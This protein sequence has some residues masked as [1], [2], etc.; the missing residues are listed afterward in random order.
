MRI[1]IQVKRDAAAQVVLNTL[2]KMSDLQITFGV[3][4]IAIVHG[5]PQLLSCATAC[6]LHRPP[7]HGGHPALALRAAQGAR[8]AGDRRGPR[9]RDRRDRPHHRAHPRL[10]GPGRGAPPCA[11][12]RW[13][14]RRLPR[15]HRSPAGRGRGR[16]G[17]AVPPQRAPGQGDPRH[18]AAAADRPRAREDRGRVPR[19]VRD[20]LVPRVDPRRPGAADGGDPRRA[21]GD[22]QRVRRRAPHPDGRGRGGDRGDRPGRRRADD[23]DA[24]QQRLHQAP[25]ER[26]VPRARAAAASASRAASAATRPTSSPSCSR[27]TRTRTCCCSPTP[28]AHVPHAGVRAA[29]GR[30][31]AP[32]RRWSTSSTCA[33]ASACSAWCRTATR[34]STTAST[35]S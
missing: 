5:R 30:R 2:Y 7:P 10:E 32:A 14:L 35:T 34:T 17:Q 11:P 25:A 22:R 18:A 26:R 9:G 13:R 1:W 15:A 28:A 23:R 12:S 20:H 8:A 16:A 6:P 24:H 33:R 4:M 27:P 3:N 19:A 21:V 31:D 29:A